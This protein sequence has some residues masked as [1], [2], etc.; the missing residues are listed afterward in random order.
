MDLPIPPA[1]DTAAVTLDTVH[2]STGVAAVHRDYGFDG[3]GQTVVVIDSGI[4]WDH[5][6]LGGGLGQGYQVVGG[7]DFAE[8]DA[9]P[10]DDPGAG[11]HG[12]HVSGII[13]ST[14]AVHR[15]VASGVD[16]VSLRVF[17]DAGNGN[18]A[19]VEQALQWV[20]DHRQDFANPITT[21]NLSLGTNWNSNDLPTW[22][23]L[24]EEF[25]QLE[26][27]GIFISV[28]AGNSF[29]NNPTIG[30]S[31]PAASQHVVPVASHDAEGEMSDFSQRNQRVLVA[32]GESIKSTVPGHLT[33]KLLSSD[34]IGASGT[35]MAA[36]Y[37]AGSSVLVRQAMQFMGYDQIDQAAI[38]QKLQETA[39][40]LFDSLT[41][42]NYHRINL[43]K[44]LQ[45]IIADHHGDTVAQATDIGILNG[46]EKLVGTIGTFGDVDV[47]QFEAG[48]SGQLTFSWEQTHDLDLKLESLGPGGANVGQSLTMQVVAGQTYTLQLS[49]NAG[50][51]H[52]TLESQLVSESSDIPS[53]GTLFSDTRSTHLTGAEWLQFQA[54][55]TGTFAVQFSP[56]SS[57]ASLQVYDTQLRPLGT[58]QQVDGKLRLDFNVQ[59]GQQ[60]LL[61]LAD[62]GDGQLIMQ[63]LVSV[64]GTT[65]TVHGT[66]QDNQIVVQ[67]GDSVQ[68]TVD[69]VDYQF[70]RSS[71]HRL[72][73]FAHSGNDELSVSH[74]VSDQIVTIQG[75]RIHTFGS[76]YQLY[77]DQ[78]GRISYQASVNDQVVLI[79][80][81]E[82]DRLI[83]DW[84]TVELQASR[85]HNTVTG[86]HRISIEGRGGDDTANVVG[87]N[88]QESVL[89]RADQT[90]LAIAG[91]WIR[92]T[93]FESMDV[94]TGGGNDRL[95]VHGSSSDESLWVDS[96]QA[97]WDGSGQ[98]R[99]FTGFQNAQFYSGGGNDSATLSG[100][101]SGNQ[102]FAHATHS[103]YQNQ[104][105]SYYLQG[106]DRT[107]ATGGSS[108]LAILFDSIGNDSYVADPAWGM[109]SGDG[110]QN[111]A[112]G[113]GI[114]IGRSTNGV[115][116]ASMSSFNPTT[117]VFSDSG[118]T[119]L[120]VGN[121][122]I[123]SVGFAGTQLSVPGLST[124]AYI[125]AFSAPTYLTVSVGHREL[126]VDDQPI[127]PASTS[128]VTLVN[129]PTVDELVFQN[130]D[131]KSSSASPADRQDS[132]RNSLPI[133]A[134]DQWAWNGMGSPLEN[135]AVDHSF[136]QW[137]S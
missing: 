85:Y 42:L 30:V 103:V 61:R 135:A 57:T 98:H 27:D 70:Q 132:P 46:N 55:R 84:Q 104:Q 6:A 88:E 119:T 32:P 134:V 67:D 21:V 34:F 54:G 106:F 121:Y 82:Q 136:G 75:Q 4:A 102:F 5:Y 35:S 128:P 14:D 28:A 125:P 71:V 100:E 105:H 96:T 97:V 77:G 53:L 91:R 31:Y 114:I 33:G 45:A 80:S 29:Q 65:V 51:G 92:A 40:T 126:I 11:F 52:Y 131:T 12:T 129:D 137:S 73:V 99:R 113:F 123:R 94:D 49:T 118:R 90:T 63:N 26:A 48:R 66:H 83:A 111:Q 41:G 72:L 13:G 56:E 87:S 116:Q 95:V 93:G 68:V 16:L 81:D 47:I 59:Q 62:H 2:Q 101:A 124:S 133:V 108:D 7:W 38:Y 115:D 117:H 110:F 39:D 64:A 76:R 43:E 74:T 50:T 69:G 44:A 112:L 60:L 24:E 109:M 89:S 15:G 37:V 78:F 86:A 79:G 1:V 22:A 8:N 122:Q 127:Q 120:S 17:D 25:A 107:S 10:F 3:T 20:H 19:W 130:W 36:P 58:A 9:D 18:L 23:T